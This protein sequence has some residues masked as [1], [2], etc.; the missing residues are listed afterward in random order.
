LSQSLASK[1]QTVDFISRRKERDGVERLAR[2]QI[3][4]ELDFQIFYI[5]GDANGPLSDEVRIGFT[6]RNA[7]ADYRKKFQLYRSRKIKEHVAICVSG[8]GTA[9]RIKA[10][11]QIRLIEE[12]RKIS[13]RWWKVTEEEIQSMMREIIETEEIKVLSE[14]E[15]EALEQ[16]KLLALMDKFSGV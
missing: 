10:A 13:E 2:L 5:I 9:R 15:A 1:M 14:A 12:W 8:E 7:Y 4:A 16:K 3:E 11:I 6:K